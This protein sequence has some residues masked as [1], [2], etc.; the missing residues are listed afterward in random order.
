MTIPESFATPLCCQVAARKYATS[1][2]LCGHL[3]GGR[4]VSALTAAV[5]LRSA[6]FLRRDPLRIREQRQQKRWKRRHA[7][8]AERCVTLAP[9][10]SLSSHRPAAAMLTLVSGG[11]CWSCSFRRCRWRRARKR[12]DADGRTKRSRRFMS[13][14]S[15]AIK[16]TTNRY[17]HP[18]CT[19]TIPA[20]RARLQFPM[21]GPPQPSQGRDAGWWLMVHVARA[22]ALPPTPNLQ[23][24]PPL[25]GL[26]PSTCVHDPC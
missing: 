14:M 17:A 26:V 12:K 15:R 1:F 18:S 2:S 19:F 20:S 8:A 9:L 16:P 4:P 11:A 24:P 5:Q 13:C 25:A 22:Q 10:P 6:H 21:R 3:S 23:T 7:A